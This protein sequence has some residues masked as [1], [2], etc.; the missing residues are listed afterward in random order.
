MRNR[1]VIDE[2]AN[3]KKIISPAGNVMYKDNPHGDIGW[4]CLLAL[5]GVPT[6]V[7]ETSAGG[8]WPCEV[9]NGQEP[10]KSRCHACGGSGIHAFQF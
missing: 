7:Q 1:Q 5:W 10:A 2:L 6:N 3:I 4:A 8:M 9:C